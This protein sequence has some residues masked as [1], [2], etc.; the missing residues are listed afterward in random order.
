VKTLR[1]YVKIEGKEI[2]PVVQKLARLAVNLSEICVWDVNMV[3]DN[4]A[5]GSGGN[6]S[7]G[8][9][10]VEMGTYF[11]MGADE[12]A[13]KCDRIISKTGSDLGTPHLL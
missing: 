6:F 5:P 12:F 3:G 10:M 7:D 2:E 4:W 13:K 9:R 11:G 8:T 1:T